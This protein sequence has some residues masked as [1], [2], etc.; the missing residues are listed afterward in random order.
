MPLQTALLAAYGIQ[1]ACYSVTDVVL[2]N[3]PHK[4]RRDE[5]A[6]H[7]IYQIK[8]VGRRAVERTCKQSTYLV[9]QTMQHESGDSGKEANKECE[10]QNEHPLTDMLLAPLKQPLKQCFRVSFYCYIRHL[11]SYYPHLTVHTQL[12][13]ARRCVRLVLLPPAPAHIV[14]GVKNIL[15]YVTI[16][17]RR[18]LTGNIG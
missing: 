6:D 8:P 12:D 16:V 9:Y 11:L 18:R 13:N 14:H 4:Q 15:R 17:L 3:I 2:D 1:Y 7:R 10:N 5:N